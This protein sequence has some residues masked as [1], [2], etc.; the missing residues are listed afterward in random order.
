[1]ATIS[2]S[3][4]TVTTLAIAGSFTATAG[5]H[6]LEDEVYSAEINS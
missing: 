5:E 6:H 1:M 4:G 2:A 3:L